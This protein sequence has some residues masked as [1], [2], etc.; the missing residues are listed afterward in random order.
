M[1]PFKRRFPSS[2]LVSALNML[3]FVHFLQQADY[4]TAA[5]SSPLDHQEIVAIATHNIDIQ[6]FQKEKARQICQASTALLETP[7]PGSAVFLGHT[8]RKSDTVATRFQSSLVSTLVN[9]SY[10]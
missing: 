2:A 6:F 8:V 7:N 1:K 3:L 9:T 5:P 10:L 4:T